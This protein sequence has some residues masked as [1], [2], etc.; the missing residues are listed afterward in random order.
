MLEFALIQ[1]PQQQSQVSQQ[2]LLNPVGN[3]LITST[4][5]GL[6][7]NPEGLA[8][9]TQTSV[10]PNIGLSFSGVGT[11]THNM[12][13]PM[14]QQDNPAV[15]TNCTALEALTVTIYLTQFC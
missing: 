10:A 6:G 11:G 8:T 4:T 12:P 2:P 9:S 7:Q 15:S 3:T 14:D 1:F 5:A 13:V